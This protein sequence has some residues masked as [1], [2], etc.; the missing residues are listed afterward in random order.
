MEGN[1]RM[2]RAMIK[3]GKMTEAE[4]NA[5]LGKP[6]TDPQGK[7]QRWPT[8]SASGMGN[9]GSQQML[10]K[11][12]DSGSLTEEEKR[13]MTAGNGGRLNPTWV[14]WLMGFPTGWTDLE[15]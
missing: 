3:A 15:D 13:G 11:H 9:T 5:I 10:Q 14:E 6:V 12:V 7:L 4:A 8:M 1:V 2:Y